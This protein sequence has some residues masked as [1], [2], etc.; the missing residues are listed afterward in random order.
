MDPSVLLQNA[1]SA[2]SAHTSGAARRRGERHSV[3]IPFVRNH[4]PLMQVQPLRG[5]SRVA[6]L[7]L[8]RSRRVSGTRVLPSPAQH[9]QAAAL[10]SRK[11][12][13]RPRGPNSEEPAQID[14]CAP[15]KHIVWLKSGT[16]F[17]AQGWHWAPLPPSDTLFLTHGW[18]CPLTMPSPALQSSAAVEAS[19]MQQA[20]DRNFIT[21]GSGLTNA[22]LLDQV[23]KSIEHIEWQQD[24]INNECNGCETYRQPSSLDALIYATRRDPGPK[25]ALLPP[26]H[27]PSPCPLPMPSL[28]LALRQPPT[29]DPVNSDCRIA[30]T[31]LGRVAGA[32]GRARRVVK[33]LHVWHR[34]SAGASCAGL[35][36]EPRVPRRFCTAAAGLHRHVRAVIRDHIGQYVIVSVIVAALVN[37]TCSNCN[38]I[39]RR[40]R[41]AYKR[42]SLYLGVEESARVGGGDRRL[43][44]R[45]E[46]GTT[47][48]AMFACLCNQCCRALSCRRRCNRRG[49]CTWARPLW[50]TLRQRH[51]PCRWSIGS[52]LRPCVGAI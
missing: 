28:P 15:S 27:A 26:P 23:C 46:A 13:N 35:D 16:W 39:V 22:V 47:R 3:A 20:G 48:A 25:A 21:P 34:V 33:R 8:G 45:S 44:A 9:R 10:S 49:R 40:K 17:A 5:D 42:C 37:G 32:S 11:R 38:C 41:E 50:C 31:L 1:L 19:G 51:S 18:H 52:G 12:T 4:C 6:K 2:Q 7:L 29:C 30:S 24:R 14:T 36:A 43:N